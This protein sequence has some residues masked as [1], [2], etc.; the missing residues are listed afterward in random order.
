MAVYADSSSIP[1][2]SYRINF[3][4]PSND[5]ATGNE[6]IEDCTM[7]ADSS[8]VTHVLREREQCGSGIMCIRLSPL[9]N[10]TASLLCSPAN[11]ISAEK[12]N[13]NNWT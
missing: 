7:K 3:R 9:L 11:D 13:S 2:K 5:G 6:L 12:K 10:I 1:Y 8:R 4:S